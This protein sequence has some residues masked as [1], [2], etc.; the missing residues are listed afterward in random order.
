MAETEVEVGRS[1]VG[2]I[3]LGNMGGAIADRLLDAGVT[4]HVRDADPGVAA[5]LVRRGA[6]AHG[7]ARDVADAAVVVIGCL[8]TMKAARSVI[9]GPG[10]IC[11]GN[12]IR[13]YVEMATV[14]ASHIQ[15]V[16]VLLAQHGVKTL[17]APVSG[18][19]AAARGGSL[20]I[21][22]GGRRDVLEAVLPV[23]QVITGTIIPIGEHVGDGQTMKLINNLLAAANMAT[24]FEALVLGTR[25]GL[26]PA[27]MADVISRSS[28][29]STGF[30]TRRVD[31][32]RSRRFDNG[33][34][35]G[36]LAKDIALAFEQVRQLGIIPDA[37]P[38]L[39]GMSA[40]WA[41]AMEQGMGT[42]DVTALVRVVEE[43]L[44]IEVHEA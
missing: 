11:N 33:G 9:D 7:S 12:G 26:S 15:D 2:M 22:A 21:M 18:G 27:L 19:A 38:S 14:G 31:A 6:T 20:T 35:I 4:L 10:G 1:S 8:P 42:Q 16:A 37:L 32:I 24:A 30:T 5:R 28:G 43:R 41:T 39:S 40:L 13:F 36:L 3:G 25:L 44:G 29:A 34:H 23:L 17:D